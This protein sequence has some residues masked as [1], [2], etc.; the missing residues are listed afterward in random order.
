LYK[1]LNGDE[2]DFQGRTLQSA[3]KRSVEH[4]PLPIYLREDD[5][6]TMAHSIEGRSPLLDYRL[7]SLAFQLPDKWKLRGP[8]N[9]YVLREA[10][11]DHIPESVR[12]RPDKMGFSVPQREWFADFLYEPMQD[13][14]SSREVRERGI[15]NVKAIQRDLDQHKQGKISLSAGFFNLFQFEIWSNIQKSHDTSGGSDYQPEKITIA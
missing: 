14:L 3:L 9:K 6:S 8:W 4:A 15:Y 11:R 10:M 2:T 13:L 7:V 5:R 1:Y 12:I